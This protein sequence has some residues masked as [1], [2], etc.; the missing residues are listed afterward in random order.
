MLGKS[1]IT[2]ARKLSKVGKIVLGST[3]LKSVKRSL[4]QC[5]AREVPYI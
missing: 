2:M 3:G 4:L 1:P 5:P